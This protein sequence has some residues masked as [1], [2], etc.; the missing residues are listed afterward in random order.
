LPSQAKKNPPVRSAALAGLEGEGSGWPYTS[1]SE[2]GEGNK[3][4]L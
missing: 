1:I 4:T 2:V 3:I